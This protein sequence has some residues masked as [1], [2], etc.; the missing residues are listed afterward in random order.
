MKF[1]RDIILG[2]II[3]GVILIGWD[4]FARRMG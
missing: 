1:D 4:P 3:C 2:I